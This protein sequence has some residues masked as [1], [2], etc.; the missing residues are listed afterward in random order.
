MK[1][2]KNKNHI[3]GNIKKKFAKTSMLLEMGEDI[4]DL[5]MKARAY[6]KNFKNKK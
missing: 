2:Q 4:M 6:K 1:K 3:K 5:M